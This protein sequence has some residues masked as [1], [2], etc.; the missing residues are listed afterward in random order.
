PSTSPTINRVKVKGS[1][2]LWIYGENFHEDSVI[3]LN[4]ILLSPKSFEHDG[5]SGQLF[6]KGKLNLGLG[7]SNLLFIQN[8]DNRSA[9][10]YF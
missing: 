1:K 2:K 5:T 6:Y 3:I 7:G 8:S 10:F 4:G 9:A